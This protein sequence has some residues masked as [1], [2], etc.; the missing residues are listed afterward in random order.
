M[1]SRAAWGLH[2]RFCLILCGLKHA[3]VKLICFMQIQILVLTLFTTSVQRKPSCLYSP[4]ISRVVLYLYSLS[5][6]DNE[7]HYS[8]Y[9]ALKYLDRCG[10]FIRGS[11]PPNNTL[12][13]HS[14][15]SRFARRTQGDRL[16]KKNHKQSFHKMKL[17]SKERKLAGNKSRGSR[18]GQSKVTK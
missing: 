4:V 7:W 10:G 12:F 11:H 15:V 5:P 2:T 1:L 9:G 8:L 13:F 14:F 3:K 16:A 18:K 17:K 6:G